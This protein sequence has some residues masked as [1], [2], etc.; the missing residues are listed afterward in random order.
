[1][2]SSKVSGK[3]TR[4]LIDIS[5]TIHPDLPCWD[6]SEGLGAHRE[7]IERRD[8]GGVAFVSKLTLVVH[9][10]TH[11]DAPSH[12]LQ[13]AFDSGR[14]IEAVQ[15][16][17]MNG[18]AVVVD[19]PHDVNITGAVLENLPIPPGTE[20]VLFKTLSSSRKLMYQTAFESSYTALTETGADWIVK[21]GIKFVGID[22]LSIATYEELAPAHQSLMR[23]GVIPV[24]GLDLSH[25]EPG[26]YD[27]HCLPLK[28]HGSDGAPGRCILLD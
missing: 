20:R 10:G 13:E 15:L 5:V 28:L 12:F 18:P 14:G 19:I 26:L 6:K 11:F 2:S 1:M 8:E 23:A 4:R 24:E 22:Y 7:L 21:A 27:V 16:S 3:N 17:V 25:V 9:T